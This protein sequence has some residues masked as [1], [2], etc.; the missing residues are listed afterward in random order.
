VEVL[1]CH[2]IDDDRLVVKTLVAWGG[3]SLE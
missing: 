2:F 1:P 3:A